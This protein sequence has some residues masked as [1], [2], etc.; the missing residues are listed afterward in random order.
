MKMGCNNFQR[1][2]EKDLRQFLKEK[3]NTKLSKEVSN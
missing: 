3:S 1:N 2:T